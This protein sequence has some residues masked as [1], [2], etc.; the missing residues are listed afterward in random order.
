MKAILM[1]LLVAVSLSAAVVGV[2][3]A[4]EDGGGGGLKLLSFTTLIGEMLTFAV[5]VVVMMKFVWPPLMNAIESRQ[6]EIAD[7]LSAAERGKQELADAEKQKASVLDAAKS[8]SSELI[9]EGEKR[10]SEIVEAAKQEAETERARIIASGHS[11]VESER[12]AMQRELEGKLSGLVL[13]GVAK[14]LDR[15]VD[16][17]TH[18][19]IID[20]LKEQIK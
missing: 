5:L 4:A 16:S 8:K 2:A 20:S 15:E 12:M 18:A 9:A 19:G 10:R 13:A 11:E 17:K 1:R 14:I 7:G 6:K 3:A